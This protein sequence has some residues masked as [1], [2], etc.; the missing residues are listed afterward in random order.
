MDEK[1]G[2]SKH[3]SKEVTE[4]I[5]RNVAAGHEKDYDDWLQHLR[6]TFSSFCLSEVE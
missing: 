3:P 2:Y 5:S 6:L 4:V 1:S